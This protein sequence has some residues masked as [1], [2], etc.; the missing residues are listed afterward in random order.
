MLTNYIGKSF[1]LEGN[2]RYLYRIKNRLLCSEFW[3]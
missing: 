3:K 1:F 2:P